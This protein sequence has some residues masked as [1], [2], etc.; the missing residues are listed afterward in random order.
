[1]VEFVSPRG[2]DFW[3][4][5][6]PEVGIVNV[7]QKNIEVL[8]ADFLHLVEQQKRTRIDRIVGGADRA[9]LCVSSLRLF[10]CLLVWDAHGS[11]ERITKHGEARKLVQ[12]LKRRNVLVAQDVCD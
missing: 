11:V 12:L 7:L 3:Q 6:F 4:V 5:E 1:V 8:D 2:Q 9:L 10:K